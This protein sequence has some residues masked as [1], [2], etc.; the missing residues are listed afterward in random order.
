MRRRGLPAAAG[1]PQSLKGSGPARSPASPRRRRSRRPPPPAAPRRRPRPSA[2]TSGGPPRH[3]GSRARDGHSPRTPAASSGGGS[4]A[5]PG[6]GPN[7]HGLGTP[8]RTESDP[9]RLE[10]AVRFERR[11][12]CV[13]RAG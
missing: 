6:P 3:G 8:A 12:T 5:L 7:S 4:A 10:S 9:A 2:R 1:S 13:S 11:S